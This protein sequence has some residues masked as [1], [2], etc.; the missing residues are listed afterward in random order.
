LRQI[1][2]VTTSLTY[3][4]LGNPGTM[5]APCGLSLQETQ[6]DPLT[7]IFHTF[8]IR[9]YLDLGQRFAGGSGSRDVDWR[10]L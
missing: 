4:A 9:V 3:L 6:V 7:P 1:K 8:A 10:H 5:L 2:A